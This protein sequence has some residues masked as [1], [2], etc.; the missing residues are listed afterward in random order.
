MNVW[1]INYR[2]CITSHIYIFIPSVYIVISFHAIL[3]LV[4]Y[5]NVFVDLFP[6]FK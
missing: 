4:L 5:G 2:I 1:R 6:E 3:L